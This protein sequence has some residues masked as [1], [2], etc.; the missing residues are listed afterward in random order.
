MAKDEWIVIEKIDKF[1][2]CYKK[3]ITGSRGLWRAENALISTL[4][5]FILQ[6]FLIILIIR[7]VALLLKP[8]RQPRIMA[9]ILVRSSS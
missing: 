7:I 4:P 1:E 6:L 5:Q 8:L 2:A 3:N 9:E